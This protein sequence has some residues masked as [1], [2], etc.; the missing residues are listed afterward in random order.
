MQLAGV[1]DCGPRHPQVLFDR[2]KIYVRDC[3]FSEREVRCFSL[4]PRGNFMDRKQEQLRG[5]SDLLDRVTGD[6]VRVWRALIRISRAVLETQRFD[7]VLEVIAEETLVALGATSVSISRWK[8]ERGV[9]RTLI[10]VGELGPGEERWP[11]NEEY[12]LTDYRCVLDSLRQGESY[13][14]AV[15]DK[16]ETTAPSVAPVRRLK[17]ASQLAVP[18]MYESRM[19]GELWATGTRGRLLGSDDVRLLESIAAQISVAIG[20]AE[21]FS[22]VSRYA[23]EDPL[24]RLANR[25]GLDECLCELAARDNAPTLLVCDLDGLK[26][27][28]DRDGHPAGDALLRGVAC[29]LR[30][31]ASDFRASLVA[32]YGGDEFCVILPT[33][34]LTEAE[35]FARIT[36]GAIARELGPEVTLCWGA[37]A[38]D[39]EISNPHELIAAADAAL[40]EAKRLGRGRMRLR[41]PGDPSMP[42]GPDRRRE[43]VASGRRS[44]DSLID[45]YVGLLDQ[46]RPTTTLAALALLAYELCHAANAAAWSVSATTD[47]FAALRTVMGVDAQLDPH[48]G[49]RV[50]EPAKDVSYSLSDYPAT[51][52]AI[53]C[54]SSFVAGLDLAGSDPAEAEELRRLGYR[55]LL[56]VGVRDSQRGYLLEV[57]S[58]G[59]HAELAA[60][61]CHARVLAHYGVRAVSGP[62]DVG[63]A[64][65]AS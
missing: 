41:G 32:R 61:A 44:V 36:S 7:D 11:A 18:V 33:P 43:P 42:M 60:I 16:D 12:S 10:N 31:V 57:Y 23:Y 27:V 52:H 53:T 20:R 3:K 2:T 25:R 54:G 56:G 30:N 14:N 46:R 55:A 49:L 9:L 62:S 24:T 21:L 48:S 19:W 35:R 4:S 6:D 39:S 38:G 13:V 26:E 37:A 15:D 63:D 64:G 45:R 34:S 65:P 8:H 51:A 29:A 50:V 17:K 59:D 22:E 5:G 1:P 40:I 58:D 28:N 47:D